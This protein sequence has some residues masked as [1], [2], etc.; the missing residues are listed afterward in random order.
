MDERP[1][2]T[3]KTQLFHVIKTT[4]LLH[5]LHLLSFHDAQLI[6]ALSPLGKTFPVAGLPLWLK[7]VQCAYSTTETNENR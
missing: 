2:S 7:T 4:P 3:T 6:S 1:I 5:L